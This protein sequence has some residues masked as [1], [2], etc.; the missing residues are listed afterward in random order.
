M[1]FWIFVPPFFKSRKSFVELLFDLMNKKFWKC[2]IFRTNLDTVDNFITDFID[3]LIQWWDYQKASQDSKDAAS[4]GYTNNKLCFMHVCKRTDFCLL[5]CCSRLFI[6]Q[7]WR[8]SEISLTKFSSFF[9]MFSFCFWPETTTSRS[10]NTFYTPEEISHRKRFWTLL[11]A[12]V[13]LGTAQF[14]LPS[15]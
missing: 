7:R 14:Q 15:A 10:R 4:W 8:P 12:F 1:C 13:H 2:F 5:R 9:K 11:I 6:V 3:R